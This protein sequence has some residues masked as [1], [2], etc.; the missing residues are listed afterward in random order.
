[1]SAVYFS[2]S[3][4]LLSMVIPKRK[5][6]YVEAYIWMFCSQFKVDLASN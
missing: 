1:M 6:Q 4:Y 2:I 3:S 5:T